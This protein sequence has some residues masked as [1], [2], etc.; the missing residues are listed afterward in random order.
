MSDAQNSCSVPSSS[1]SP[2]AVPSNNPVPP[3]PLAAP[4]T[5][6]FAPPTPVTPLPAP[7]WPFAS[8]IPLTYGQPHTTLRH[9]HL[10]PSMIH[11]C[12]SQQYQPYPA[13]LNSCRHHRI[14]ILHGHWL[15]P[16][17]E[18]LKRQPHDHERR[19]YT[20]REPQAHEPTK[21]QEHINDELTAAKGITQ[22]QIM[23]A[24]LYV[25]E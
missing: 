1:P 6:S 9:V 13:Y 22:S 14:R 5:I 23:Q 4:E 10:D 21:F 17:I 8:R 12:Q 3:S 25:E 15:F 11:Q 18:K 2:F 20:P 16:T 19:T 7:P 24:K